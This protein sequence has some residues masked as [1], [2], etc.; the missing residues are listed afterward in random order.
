MP[1]GAGKRPRLAAAA[2]RARAAA[3]H[4]AARAVPCRRRRRGTSDLV[5][6]AT[7]RARLEPE[8]LQAQPRLARLALDRAPRVPLGC[9]T[10]RR[11]RRPGSRSRVIERHDVAAAAPPLVAAQAHD[12]VAAS[13][14]R[15]R[16]LP[17]ARV[18]S[19]AATRA[20]ARRVRRRSR[21]TRPARTCC[22]ELRFLAGAM[23]GGEMIE[24]AAAQ[25][26]ALAD[27]Q[28]RA[29]FAAEQVHARA[30]RQV[31]G[32]VR[33]QVRRQARLAQRRRRPP[34]CIASAPRSRSI[35]A[36]SAG[37]TCASPSARWRAPHARP[38]RSISVSRLWRACSRDRARATAARCTAPA[39]EN[40][41][42]SAAEL[43]AQEAVVEARVVRDEQPALEPAPHL[44]RARRRKAARPRPS[45]R[46]CR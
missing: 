36:S 44:A 15:R 37:S 41:S 34:A 39:R 31:V 19:P 13:A 33:R 46:R 42:P 43:A 38:K 11:R 26:A 24:H 18:P 10:A 28:Q 17:S 35:A 6:E 22:V 9:G 21:S 5:G 40:V 4:R 2:T 25:V 7:A 12:A 8:H 14:W 29:A 23:L 16:R 32:E 45:S 30:F 1:I 27:V 20:A 3:A